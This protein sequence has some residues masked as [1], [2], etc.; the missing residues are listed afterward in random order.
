MSSEPLVPSSVLIPTNAPLVA[1]A[2]NPVAIRA[3]GLGKLYRIG[4]TQGA[5]RYRL[6][7][8]EVAE[9]VR[10]RGRKASDAG[11]RTFWALRN[12]TF[13]V[14]VSRGKEAAENLKL[15]A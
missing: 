11:G 3:E 9:R 5:Y 10:R 8:E 12:V 4:A 13:D 2:G 6:L 7:G 15:A 1:A 14:V